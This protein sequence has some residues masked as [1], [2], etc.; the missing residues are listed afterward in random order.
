[1]E[2]FPSFVLVFESGSG[3]WIDFRDGKLKYTSDYE[4]ASHFTDL[5]LFNAYGNHNDFKSFER[6]MYVEVREDSK[7]LFDQFD[8]MLVTDFLRMRGFLT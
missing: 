7:T 8:R 2:N 6:T 3:K 5:A 4:R 1:M